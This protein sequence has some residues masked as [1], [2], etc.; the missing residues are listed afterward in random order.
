MSNSEQEE[1]HEARIRLAFGDTTEYI[2]RFLD[3]K[4]LYACSQI[5]KYVENYKN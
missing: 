2:F 4:D 3:M 1:D 5:W